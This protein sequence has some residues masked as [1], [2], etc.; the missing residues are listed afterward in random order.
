MQRRLFF[1]ATVLVLLFAGCGQ[2]TPVPTPVPQATREPSATAEPRPEPT[3]VATTLPA[4]TAT[5]EP[6]KISMVP[7]TSENYGFHGVAP[8]GWRE[9][10]PATFARGDWPVDPTALFLQAFPGITADWLIAQSVLPQLGIAELPS[11]SGTYQSTALTWELYVAEARP[12]D[13]G[14]VRVAVATAED[15]AGVYLAA[16]VT[17]PDEHDSMYDT[18]FLP[19]LEA[20]EPPSA[21]Q[22]DKV[23]AEALLAADYQGDGPVNNR[24]F[25][26]IG[27]AELPLHQL[28]GRLTVPEFE[29][30]ARYLPTDTP[31]GRSIFPGFSAEFFTYQ[32]YLVPADRGLLSA[33]GE[34]SDYRIILSPGQ[35]WAEPGDGGMSRAAFPFVLAAIATNDAYNGIATFLYDE[36]TVSFFR[37]QV[38]QEIGRVDD[39]WGQ[40]ALSYVPGA[41]TER[42]TL[43]DQFA[44]ELSALLPWRPWLELEA[45]SDARLLYHFT[46]PV[47]W[48]N[49]S[50]TGLIWGD[51]LYMPP[52]Y[53]RYGIFPY[54]RFMRHGSFSVAKSMGAALA[55][56]R[57]AEKYGEEVFQLKISDY[58]QVTAAHDGWSE[59]TFGDALNMATGVGDA[60]PGATPSEAMLENDA[61]TRFLA[62]LDARSAQEK[63]DACFTAG[64][65]P[66]GPGE[67][68][69]YSSCDTFILSVALRNF[70]RSREGPDAD[71]WDMVVEEVL[72]PIGIQHAPI[73]RTIEPDGSRGVPQF[74]IGLYPTVDDAAKVAML[75]RDGG[76]YQGRQ[77]L[78]AGRIAEALRQTDWAG[79]PSGETNAVGE[80]TYLLSFWAMPYRTADGRTLQ[81]PYMSGF[82]GN[83]IV[84]NPNGII[85]FRFTDAHDYDSTPLMRVAESI[86]PFPR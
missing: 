15:D 66:W 76:Q 32:D 84:F 55:M 81:I 33:Q 8:A 14:R 9:I 30:Q 24:Y 52:C 64:D 48:P 13:V 63:L 20:M 62:F 86:A 44:Q 58:V 49:T 68:A 54:C 21:E 71:V 45:Y 2:S 38:V 1:A 37:F 7:Y 73:L 42:E 50:A 82:G 57:L 23:A 25:A 22:R 3:S 31:A 56:F 51:T 78:H 59:V 28:E 79:F 80:G 65:Y 74:W 17:S 85:C 26:P 10:Q 43:A 39:F 75:L 5:A 46:G 83:R 34:N 53:T 60:I 19:A 18:V 70:Y 36:T 11:G 40:S 69:R 35:V 47:G 4:A 6:D 72:K 16:L 77:I 29:M 27:E 61:G 41:V 67:V 12:P